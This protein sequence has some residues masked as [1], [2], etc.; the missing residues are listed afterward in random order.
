MKIVAA[1]TDSDR[2]RPAMK[3]VAARPGGPSW[4][5]G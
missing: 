1:E 3:D 2:A 4:R 5:P